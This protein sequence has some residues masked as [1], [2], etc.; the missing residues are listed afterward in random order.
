RV[1]RPPYSAGARFGLTNGHE[2]VGCEPR[3]L[4]RASVG[5]VHTQRIDDIVLSNPEVEHIV[6]TRLETAGGGLLLHVQC[7]T[8]MHGD[9]GADAEAVTTFAD[10]PDAKE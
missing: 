6:D 3:Y 9:A 1:R 10:E 2:F 8:S 5:P 7:I 4:A